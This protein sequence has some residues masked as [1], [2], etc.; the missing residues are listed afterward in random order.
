MKTP[1]QTLKVAIDSSNPLITR[2]RMEKLELLNHLIANLARALIICGPE[3]V[4]KTYLL[5]HFQESIPAAWILCPVQGGMDLTLEKIQAALS[6]SISQA[7]PNLAFRSLS[8][9][10]DRLAGNDSKIILIIDSAGQLAPGLLGEVLAFVD[11]K[12]AVRAIFALNHNEL[13]LK[14]S[15][16]PAIDNCYQ[17]EVPALTEQQC[18][19][20]LEYLSS[21]PKPRVQFHTISDNTIAELYRETHGIPGNIIN[22]FPEPKK[23]VTDYFSAGLV[24]AVAALIVLA[25]GVQ[26]WSAKPANERVLWSFDNINETSKQINVTQQ[27]KR[28]SKTVTPAIPVQQLESATRVDIA[29]VRNDVID[30]PRGHKIMDDG[31]LPKETRVIPLQPLPQESASKQ[32]TVNSEVVKKPENELIPAGQAELRQVLEDGGNWLKN[33]PMT[34]STLQLMALSKLDPINEVVQRYHQELGQQL[35]VVKTQS[36]S[37]R[38][39]FILLFGSFAAPGEAN[40]EAQ[41]LPKELQKFWRRNIDAVQ[42]ELPESI[43]ISTPTP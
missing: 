28:D 21:L 42:K 12:P 14:N 33:Q 25:M 23:K 16:D 22:Y 41:K 17:I 2:E 4:G 7:M 32:T 9:A 24:A 3:G 27:D 35:K 40:I 26:W 30:D 15:S 38:D 1:N 18:G 20:F 13:Y 8:N 11:G 34:N 6:Q 31:E 19:E 36:K 37:G 10:F 29:T 39:R 5:K 43:A